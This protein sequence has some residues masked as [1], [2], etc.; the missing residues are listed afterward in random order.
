VIVDGVNQ[1]SKPSSYTFF[2][3][4][5]NHTIRS[6]FA[7][8]TFTITAKQQLQR[9]DQPVGCQDGQLQRQREFTFSP[10]ANY[11]VDSLI[12]DGVKVT[13][14]SSYTFFNVRQGIRSG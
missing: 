2:N 3:V 9:D 7:I 13:S 5:A 4:T 1:V 14:A 8:N 10:S 12:V 11:H 6:V